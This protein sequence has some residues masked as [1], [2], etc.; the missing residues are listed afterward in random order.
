VSWR[1]RHAAVT[2][3]TPGPWQIC[4]RHGQLTSVA[5]TLYASAAIEAI[6]LLAQDT[7]GG[8][9]QATITDA[10]GIERLIAFYK[11]PERSE[12]AKLAVKRALRSLILHPPAKKQMVSFGIVAPRKP[13]EVIGAGAD[14]FPGLV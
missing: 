9:G 13:G 11:A 12:T 7:S 2:Q 8:T 3:T 10:N 4:G 5:C 1:L 6:A 14:P